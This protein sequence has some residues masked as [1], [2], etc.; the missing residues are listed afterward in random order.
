MPWYAHMQQ[1]QQQ[2]AVQRVGMIAMMMMATRSQHSRGYQT[3]LGRQCIPYRCVLHHAHPEFLSTCQPQ[4]AGVCALF[5]YWI[6]SKIYVSY[7]LVQRT[8][9]RCMRMSLTCPSRTC[10]LVDCDVFCPNLRVLAGTALC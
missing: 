6:C 2:A 10:F 3:C 7:Q 5:V 9:T 8:P 4:R 1:K